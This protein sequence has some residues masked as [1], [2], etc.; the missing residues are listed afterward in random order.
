MNKSVA[1]FFLSFFMLTALSFEG[2]ANIRLPGVLSNNMVL[3]QQST[4]NLWGWSAPGEKIF[5]TT[6]WSTITDSTMA[7]GDAKWDIAVKTPAAGGPYTITFKGNNTVVL[8]NI[9]VGEVWVCSGQ[10]NMEWS[11]LNGLPQIEAGLPNS[12][13]TNIRFFHIP[14]TTAL[15]PQEDCAATWAECNPE[16]LKSFSAVAYYFGKQLQQ[17]LNVPIGL[18]NT[19]WGGTPAEVWTP[20][21]AVEKDPEL[22]AAAATIGATNWWPNAPGRAYNAMIAPVTP[23]NIA[24]AVWYQGESN[25]GTASTYKKL[26]ITLIDS[27]RKDWNRDIPFYYVQIAPFAYGNKNIGALLREAQTQT[28]THPNTGMAVITDLVDNVKDIHPKNK[29]DVG[30]RLA[31]W[32][33]AETYHKEGLAYKSPMYKNMVVNKNKVTVYFNNAPNG[34]VVTGGEKKA[35]EFYIAGEDKNFL[36]ADVKI[37]GDHV[38]LSNKQI[39]NPVA[40]RF[41]FSNT[42]IAN[43]FSKEGLPVNPFRTDNWEVDTGKAE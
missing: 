15:T 22:K 2:F 42:A 14:K 29:Q 7:S 13:N 37:E 11:S 32:A 24:G 41:A 23:F 6:S 38:I 27:W 43:I 21:E 10:S 28:L 12:A 33:L 30:Y 40:V 8:H 39:K 1:L 3:Q 26:M 31:A 34:L 19:S 18:I 20:E 5:I 9:M 36:P 17:K 16:T 4:V 35:T 25:T